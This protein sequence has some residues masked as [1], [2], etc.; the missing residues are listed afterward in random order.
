MNIKSCRRY[1][2]Q[3]LGLV[4][5][6]LCLDA[7]A[8]AGAGA[9]EDLSLSLSTDSSIAVPGRSI[10]YLLFVRNL[11]E[12]TQTG[13]RLTVGLPADLSCL[14]SRRDVAGT[15]SGGALSGSGDLDEELNLSSDAVVEY[16]LTCQVAAGATGVVSLSGSISS[17]LT[18][19][20]SANDT[21][22]V[23]TVVTA[24]PDLVFG[25]GSGTDGGE[26]DRLCQ[27]NGVETFVCSDLEA[28]I[29]RTEQL[30][31]GDLDN[32]GLMDVVVSF[33]GRSSFR[34]CMNVG[35]VSFS[36][37]DIAVPTVNPTGEDIALG[38]LNGDGFLDVIFA[39]QIAADLACLNTG[40]GSFLPCT[41][42]GDGG[43]TDTDGV[44][45][46]DLDGDGFLDV[47]SAQVSAQNEFCLG[48]GDGTFDSCQVLDPGESPSLPFMSIRVAV[49]DM[50]RDGDLDAL[51]ANYTDPNRYC[52]NDGD[53]NFICSDLGDPIARTQA[54]AVADLNGDAWLDVVF[55]NDGSTSQNRLCLNDGNGN[56]LPCT[57]FGVDDEDTLEVAVA[58][59]NVDGQPDVIVANGN[60]GPNRICYG[61]G[62]GSF[63]S[64]EALSASGTDGVAVAASEFA[65]FSSI[66]LSVAISDT[67]DPVE[68]DDGT[69]TYQVEL[70][71]HSTV[72]TATGVMVSLTEMLPSGMTITDVTPSPGSTYTAPVWLL[73]LSPDS[74][75]TLDVDIAVG[76]STP[77]GVDVASLMA[78]ITDADQILFNLDDDTAI[79]KTS[80]R[81][82]LSLDIDGDGE[83]LPLSDG[84]LIFRFISG[85]RGDALIADAVASGAV[86]TTAAQITAWLQML[87]DFD[88]LDFDG[89]GE[90]TL[91]SDGQ[92][93]SRYL[94][95][96]DGQDLID[97]VLG[98]DPERDDP[99]EI[100]AFIEEF[101][102]LKSGFD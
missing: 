1:L 101:L 66:D 29:A 91:D 45:L 70:Q 60:A 78:D 16:L 94:F 22:S 35:G 58:D 50:D 99:E 40:A 76:P 39:I 56:L 51:F 69:L 72:T 46:G 84:L 30:V 23:D 27:G 59:M 5:V 52:R 26:V 19:D 6:A 44:A 88:V 85:L 61:S 57:P 102:I 96:Y 24:H 74:T 28:L 21:A 55:V 32:D 18:D 37:S 42:V 90:V 34:R 15:I 80:S 10:V 81:V 67:P 75:A 36:C 92:L 95:G 7:R 12:S 63:S 41:A 54:L 65:L 83:I 73:D 33:R 87:M 47:V 48:R 20:R 62:D 3:L 25:N 8:G 2:S 100:E 31:A 38:D 68:P 82:N 98:E 9:I 93:I 64:C 71:N 11:G 17:A 89:N 49:A 14:W 53:A 43:G 77:P 86:R 97:Q 79:E 4:L 13:A